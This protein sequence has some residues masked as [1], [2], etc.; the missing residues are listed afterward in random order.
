MEPCGCCAECSLTG[1][2][3]P[4][5]LCTSEFPDLKHR[6]ANAGHEFSPYYKVLRVKPIDLKG[7][8][9]LQKARYCVCGDF[10][11]QD[12]DYDPH[13]TYVSVASH[14]AMQILFTY[15]TPNDVTVEGGDDVTNAY[16]DC[17]V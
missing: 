3:R 11:V 1:H 13:G 15:A 12:I 2:H 10:Q 8:N 6:P 9:V 14:E 7:R 5:I 17:C 16:I 4:Q